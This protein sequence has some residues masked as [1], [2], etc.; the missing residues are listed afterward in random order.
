MLMVRLAHPLFGE[1][2]RATAGEMHLSQIRGR[3]AQRLA[4]DIDADMHATVRRALLALESDLPAD[5]DLFLVSAR[6]AMTLLDLGLADRFATAAAAAGAAEA[7]G[8]R[9]MNLVL[10]G[11]GQEAEA[12]L[13]VI[14]DDDERPDRHHWSTLRA[15]NL[16]WMLGRPRDASIILDSL[17]APGESAADRAERAAVEACVDVVLARCESAVEKSR[18]AL[19]FADLPDFHAMMASMALVMALGALGQVDDITEVASEA[20]HRA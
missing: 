19:R 18:A 6:F 17:S 11:R 2:R 16:I 12:V 7:E 20:L 15:A 13:Q 3:L 10:L 4:K 8:L 5:P 14:T 9:A 1:L